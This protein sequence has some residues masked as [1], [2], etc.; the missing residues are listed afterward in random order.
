MVSYANSDFDIL[1][2]MR[3]HCL[4]VIGAGEKLRPRVE[5]WVDT[6]EDTANALS[7]ESCARRRSCTRAW[8]TYAD[9][10]SDWQQHGSRELLQAPNSPMT[11]PSAAVI[12]RAVPA[13][14]GLVG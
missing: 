7:S 5:A 1:T 10:R 3:A 6:R 4:D 11:A 13:V 14:V 8:P 9:Y 2:C 12:R